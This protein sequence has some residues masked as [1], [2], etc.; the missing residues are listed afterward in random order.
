[1]SKLNTAAAQNFICTTDKAKKYSNAGIR[2]N[3]RM[4]KAE[5]FLI[6]LTLL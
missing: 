5:Y 6:A 4:D 3:A 1:M 2:I